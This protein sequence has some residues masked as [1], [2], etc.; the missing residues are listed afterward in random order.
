M[1]MLVTEGHTEE[2]NTEFDEEDIAQKSGQRS[3][4]DGLRTPSSARDR[5]YSCACPL[6]PQGRRKGSLWGDFV[7]RDGRWS[8]ARSIGTLANSGHREAEQLRVVRQ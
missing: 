8:Q 3:R 5:L 2:D 1:E 6:R 7:P 4:V